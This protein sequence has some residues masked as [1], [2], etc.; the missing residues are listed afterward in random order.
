MTWDCMS[1]Y[2]TKY[3]M[4]IIDKSLEEV[5]MKYWNPEGK[6]HQVWS[7]NNFELFY[8]LLNVEGILDKNV[9]L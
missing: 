8:I 2:H 6:K 4:K 7:T 1:T 5:G 3:K 9:V